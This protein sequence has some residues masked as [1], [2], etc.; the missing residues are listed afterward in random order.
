MS[1]AVD[2]LAG[3]LVGGLEA[4]ASVGAVAVVVPQS[5]A[6]GDGDVVVVVEPPPVCELPP[7]AGVEGLDDPILPGAARF[8][9]DGLDAVGGHELRAVGGP[10]VLGPGLLAD[11]G[12]E[13]DAGDVLLLDGRSHL[14]SQD[15]L[16][17]LVDAE[18]DARGAPLPRAEHHEVPSPDLVGSGGLAHVRARRAAAAADTGLRSFTACSATIR[19]SLGWCLCAML[20]VLFVILVLL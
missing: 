17:V 5:V 9:V 15:A 20:G 1:S 14:A 6:H 10:D 11:H 8:D 7:E 4:Q 2:G 19:A 3:E 16:G 12:L 13:E 18:E